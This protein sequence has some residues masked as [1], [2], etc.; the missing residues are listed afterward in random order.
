[1]TYENITAVVLAGGRS[2][3]MGR[4][5]AF[6]K[7]GHKTMIET[8]VESLQKIFRNV[9]VVTNTPEKYTMLNQVEFIQ[10]IIDTKEKKSLIGLYSGLVASKTDYVFVTGCDMPFVNIEFIKYMIESIK[11][12]DIVVPFCY[13][14]YEPLYAIYGK[15]C[16][17]GFKEL[18]EKNKFKIIDIFKN[19]NVKEIQKSE[20]RKFD[21]N[22][23]C[24][25]NI[26]TYEQY[27]EIKDLFN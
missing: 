1:M 27:M 8:I 11:D 16:I 14:H 17:P 21:K 13:D 20:I 3:R 15:R 7:L 4:N 5:K 23:L 9:I 10:D 19:L 24:F 25:K 12:E 22:T 18:I 2:S 26:N 6:L